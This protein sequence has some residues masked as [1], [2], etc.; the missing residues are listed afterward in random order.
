MHESPLKII[1]FIL[2]F[3]FKVSQIEIITILEE[4]KFLEIEFITFTILLFF[5]SKIILII[6]GTKIKIQ[7]VCSKK[8]L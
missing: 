5:K 4:N 2:T 8:R 1:L 6:I 7:N 3:N